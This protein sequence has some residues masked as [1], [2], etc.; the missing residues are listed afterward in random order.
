MEASGKPMSS[1]QKGLT[2]EHKEEAKSE[3][4][5]QGQRGTADAAKSQSKDTLSTQ[6]K[7]S[8]AEDPQ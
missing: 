7:G 3:R 4:R 8:T 2:G 5:W 6:F 1:G